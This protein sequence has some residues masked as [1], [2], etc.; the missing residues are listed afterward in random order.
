ML[1]K[2]VIIF[3]RT[4]WHEPPRI[5]HQFTKMLL[6]LGYEVTYVETLFLQRKSNMTNE[7]SNLKIVTLREFVHHQLKFFSLISIL[8]WFFV[9]FQLKLLSIKKDNYSIVVNFNYDFYFLHKLFPN[10]KLITLLNDDFVAMAKPWMKSQ[11][12]HLISKTCNSSDMILS[13]SYSIHSQVLLFSNKAKLFLPWSD[14]AYRKPTVNKIRDVILYFGFISRFDIDL[15]KE[16]CK[17]GLKIRFVGP[18]QGNGTII[19]ELISE[20]KNVEYLGAVNSFDEIPTDD[21]CCSMAFYDTNDMSNVAITASNRMF[22]LLS[23]GIPLVYPFM[24]N[25]IEAPNTVIR[26]CENANDFFNAYDFFYK[27]F[28]SVQSDIQEFLHA[29]TYQQ[30]EIDLKKIIHVI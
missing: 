17:R 7:T 26:K 15:V 23:H 1:N 25:L 30:R 11:T 21:I 19:K 10:A 22:R 12:L 20:F 2:R 5:R 6:N 14:S 28:E 8:N 16:V 24:P 27:N 18:I 9:N 3:S 29:H 4:P 13:V